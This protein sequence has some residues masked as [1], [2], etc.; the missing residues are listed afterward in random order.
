[1]QVLVGMLVKKGVLD[2]AEIYDMWKELERQH[3]NA[4]HPL[5]RNINDAAAQAA[6]GISTL[7]DMPPV[8]EQ[9]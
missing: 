5:R 2:R 3:R 4:T 8:K 1:M 7:Y 6:A 9:H